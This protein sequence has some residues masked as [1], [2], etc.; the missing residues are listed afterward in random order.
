M[1]WLAKTVLPK[2][3]AL[4]N[5]DSVKENLWV[6]C[7]SC[8]QM[9]F[10]REFEEQFNTCTTCGNHMPLPPHR[11]MELLC[12]GGQAALIALDANTDDPLQFGAL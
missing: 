12:D 2:I 8:A 4:V 6:K 1:N 11:R 7:S 10:H 3:K 5:Q 9:I